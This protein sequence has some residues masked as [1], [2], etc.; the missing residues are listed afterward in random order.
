MLDRAIAL[1][2][3]LLC[4]G[5]SRTNAFPGLNGEVLV[6]AYHEKHYYEFC[7]ELDGMVTFVHEIDDEEI[8]RRERLA[9]DEVG[10]IIAQM[11][12]AA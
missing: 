3:E 12:G 8:G 9:P 4:Q 11:V 5:Y 1:H 2:R 7:L 10:V 6:T